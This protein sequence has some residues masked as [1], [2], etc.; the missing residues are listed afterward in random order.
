MKS[1]ECEY[2]EFK[3]VEVRKLKKKLAAQL[4]VLAKAYA[5]FKVGDIIG[6]HNGVLQIDK[7]IADVSF[8][9]PCIVYHGK[10]MTK[11]NKPFKDESTLS[12][13][14]HSGDHSAIK[15]IKSAE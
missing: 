1:F 11:N 7:V 4:R 8:G 14:A 5:E 13:W 15:L 12:I 2:I 10:K 3:E 9:K 6:S